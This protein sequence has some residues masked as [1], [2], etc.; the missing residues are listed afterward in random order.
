[1]VTQTILPKS[2]AAP[3]TVRCIRIQPDTGLNHSNQIYEAE[4]FIRVVDNN[5]NTTLKFRPYNRAVWQYPA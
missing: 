4:G 5:I 3:A 1:M 2:I